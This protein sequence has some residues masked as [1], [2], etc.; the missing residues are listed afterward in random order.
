MYK[1]QVSAIVMKTR[2]ETNRIAVE[3]RLAQGH[4]ACQMFAMMPRWSLFSS[5]ACSITKTGSKSGFDSLMYGSIT[6]RCIT[7]YVLQGINAPRRDRNGERR[8]C[9][10]LAGISVASRLVFTLGKRNTYKR[11]RAIVTFN[12]W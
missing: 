2:N 3:R 1:R 10:E 9:A 4:M 5:G 12:W 11:N 7:R 6:L 8:E